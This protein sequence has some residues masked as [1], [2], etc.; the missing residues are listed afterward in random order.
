M[1]A[2][3]RIFPVL[4]AAAVALAPCIGLCSVESSLTA[5]QSRLV[6]QILPL[7][8]ILGLVFAGLSFVAGSQN[9]RTHLVLAVIGAAVGFGAQSIIN[10]VRELV[11]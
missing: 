11:H 5:I 8:A 7:A 1:N 2:Q 4:V 6:D 3:K 10:L 9:A